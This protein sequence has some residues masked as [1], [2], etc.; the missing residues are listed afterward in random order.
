LTGN[1]K[2][3]VI[4]NLPTFF[5]GGKDTGKGVLGGMP[6]A[7]EKR[8][9]GE[10]L[11]YPQWVGKTIDRES[12]AEAKAGRTSGNELT[13]RA[14]SSSVESIEAAFA[15]RGSDLSVYDQLL[16]VAA[17]QYL[18]EALGKE[19]PNPTELKIQNMFGKVAE[20]SDVSYEIFE[21]SVRESAIRVM[22]Q[23]D[24]KWSDIEP[25]VK[26]SRKIFTDLLG[27]ENIEKLFTN[28]PR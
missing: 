27:I 3:A 13:R 7:I 18:T 16:R 22:E 19:N 8:V 11:K 26:N 1:N 12:M 4:E 10:W 2:D 24:V 14:P 21:S 17:M 25:V 5:L 15:K 23:R 28:E 9:N 20:N 6:F